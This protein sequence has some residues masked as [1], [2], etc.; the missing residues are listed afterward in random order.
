MPKREA[1]M[2]R[3]DME[4]MGAVRLNDVEAK[5]AIICG[6]ILDMEREGVIYIARGGEEELL[7]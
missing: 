5:Q 4:N 1:A 7:I 3:E 6:Q 2:L